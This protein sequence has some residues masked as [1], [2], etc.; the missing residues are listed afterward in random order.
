MTFSL[1]KESNVNDNKN[2]KI[3]TIQITSYDNK[4][5]QFIK[6]VYLI[7]NNINIKERKIDNNISPINENNKM[8]KIGSVNEIEIKKIKKDN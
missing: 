4:N 8:G 2:L 1:I 7:N 6:K 5:E 3:N